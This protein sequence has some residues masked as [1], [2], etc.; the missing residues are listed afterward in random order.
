MNAKHTVN[1]FFLGVLLGL[2]VLGSVG[3]AVNTN[4]MTLPNPH[5]MGNH[6]QYFPPGNEFPFSREAASLQA[7]QPDRL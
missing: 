4:G 6:V 1:R 5:Y 7:A 2:I 3:C